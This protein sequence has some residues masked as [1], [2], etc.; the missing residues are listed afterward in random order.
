MPAAP[1][2]PIDP[3]ICQL[4]AAAE[5]VGGDRATVLSVHRRDEEDHERLGKEIDSMMIGLGTELK[6]LRTRRNEFDYSPHPGPDDRTAYDASTIE[7][8]IKE[9]LDTAEKLVRAF[10]KRLKER[11]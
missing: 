7:A 1:S 6:E 2:S 4:L 3:A 9:S 11:G 5:G 10:E 8:M